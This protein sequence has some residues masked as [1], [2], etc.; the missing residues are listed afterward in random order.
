M[1]FK[2]NNKPVLSDL[3]L[4][5]ILYSSPLPPSATLR[6]IKDYFIFRERGV[7]EI[8]K[9]DELSGVREGLKTF[10]E[11]KLAELK[12]Q[13][14]NTELLLQQLS[15]LLLVFTVSLPLIVAGL[16]F[17][18]GPEQGII[19]L[20]TLSL[21]G[22]IIGVI[23]FTQVPPELRFPLL[24]KNSYLA[25]FLLILPIITNAFYH[26]DSALFL[27]LS[28]FSIPSAVIALL[29]EKKIIRELDENQ[30]ILTE[31]MKC[32]FHLYR[33]IGL[34]HLNSPVVMNISRTIRTILNL[35]GK[36]G[37]EKRGLLWLSE[38]YKQV[39]KLVRD[40]RARTLMALFNGF[41]GIAVLALGLSMIQSVFSSLPNINLQFINM[42][43]QIYMNIKPRLYIVLGINS[44]S[45]SIATSSVREG[46][47]L[48][49]TI[50]LP[51]MFFATYIGLFIGPLIM[52]TM[53]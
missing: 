19:T 11:N 12:I 3:D 52:P 15:D 5:I 10:I 18:L 20:L 37:T 45:Y 27:L 31:A 17:M 25:L 6:R 40:T 8:A 38:Y 28:L 21:M 41:I 24:S 26:L 51:S 49:F 2:L 44:I 30:Q 29:D 9:R 4:A 50:Y 23:S 14:E 34:E 22:L 47:P 35:Y 53:V 43:P 16:L 7:A 48:Y 1:V 13:V 46:N 39:V 36:F 42:G 32:P 33:C